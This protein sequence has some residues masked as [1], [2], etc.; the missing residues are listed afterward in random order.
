MKRTVRFLTSLFLF[1]CL[2]VANT[3]AEVFRVHRTVVMQMPNAGTA[4]CQAG[5]NDAISIQL[6][7]DTTF[8]QAVELE[9]KIPETIAQYRDS[10][11]YSLYT[12]VEPPPSGRTI[13]YSGKR[14]LI[15]TMPG[16]LSLNVTIPLMQDHTVKQSPYTNILPVVYEKTDDFIFFRLQLVMKGIPDSFDQEQFHVTAKPVYIDKGRMR[17]ELEYPMNEDLS[18]IVKP[19]S[20]FIDE[21][22]VTLE[23][24]ATILDTGIHHLSIVSDFYRNETRMFSIEQ[25]QDTSVRIQLRDIAPTL[26]LV[27][28]DGT[29]IFLDENK[30]ENSKEP[31]IITQGDHTIKFIVGDYE[32]TKTVQATNGRSYTVNL[33]IVIDVTE[34]Q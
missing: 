34:T 32:V 18:P 14:E 25:A 29:L 2:Y 16:R 8:L 9:I 3:T 10:V 22:P 12:G 6:P 5:I 31:F 26:Q 17:L 27:V 23:E 28:P 15:D 13:D 24:N 1:S 21:R 19:Y 33:S 11:A 4:E 20:V 30:I 7:E